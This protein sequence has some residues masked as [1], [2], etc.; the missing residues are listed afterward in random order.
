MEGI[1][2]PKK[3]YEWMPEGRTRKGRPK[4][5]WAQGIAQTIRGQP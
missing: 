3:I 4:L 2:L 5:T 1:R